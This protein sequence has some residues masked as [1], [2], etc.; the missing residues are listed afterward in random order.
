ME[1]Y[2]EAVRLFREAL[3]YIAKFK[4]S[5]FVVKYGGAALDNKETRKDVT[6]DIILLSYVGIKPVIVH[7]GGKEIDRI[8]EKM[9]IKSRKK[10]GVRIT[11]SIESVRGGLSAS[12][13][14]IS[15]VIN[16]NCGKAMGITGTDGSLIIP[17]SYGEGYGQTGDVAK[18][19]P[20]IVIDAI[21]K[22]YT[23]VISTY[24]AYGEDGTC[25]NIN[26]DT[27]AG[28]LAA[29][30]KAKKLILLTDAPGILKDEKD[31]DTL[32]KTIKTSEIKMLKEK[33]IIS[34][35]MIPKI[36]ACQIALEGGVEKTHIVDGR[37]P[38]SLLLELL[39]KQGIGTEIVL[40]NDDNREMR[41]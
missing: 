16:W 3:P 28:H 29:S 39:T 32:I 20:Q 4:D 8:E 36:H 5:I 34:S 38:G 24:A 2:L 25:Y 11:E 21:E 18:I 6:R 33:G 19:N 12:R 23:P 41:E 22:G 26:A 9:G 37:K 40:H 27:V 17:K 15:S 14:Y 1:K 7:G 10:D 31:E 35:G 13:D 30:L